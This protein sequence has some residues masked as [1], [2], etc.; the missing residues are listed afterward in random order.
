MIQ[1]LI[2]WFFNFLCSF[3][4]FYKLLNLK[5]PNSFYKLPFLVL[6]FIEAFSSVYLIPIF[7]YSFF[8]W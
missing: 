4:L 8:L 1:D 3:Y 2:R 6:I 7:L 5:Q